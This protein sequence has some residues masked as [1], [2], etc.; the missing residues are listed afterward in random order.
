MLKYGDRGPAVEALQEK[1]IRLG[2]APVVVDGLFGPITRWAVLN[3]QAMFGY[4]ID[5]IAA[6]GTMR[7]ISMKI[8]SGW[9]R[10]APGDLK[11]ALVTQ[12][13][14]PREPVQGE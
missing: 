1:L 8:D 6:R 4:T 7:L 3:L 13:L 14:L 2:Y 5:G 12:G 10:G 9:V 11:R